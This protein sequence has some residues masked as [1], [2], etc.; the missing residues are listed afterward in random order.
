[1]GI[2]E[3][4]VFAIAAIAVIAIIVI[5][6]RQ[7]LSKGVPVITPPTDGTKLVNSN[8]VLPKSL[9]EDKGLELA[10][11][12][13]VKID[14]FA[15]KYGQPKVVFVKGSPDMSSMCPALLIDPNTNSFL[16]KLDTFAGTEV[17]PVGNIPAKKWIH[18]AISVGQHAMDIYINGKLYLHHT[19]IQLPKQNEGTLHSGVN[20]G[21][22]GQISQLQYFPY[23]LSPDQVST[24]VSQAPASSPKTQT[25]PIPPYFDSSFW[26][27]HK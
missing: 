23:L 20:G 14:D 9:N 12:C 10:V 6:V 24:L 18:V 27:S 21:F 11:A 13:W 17:V 19:L 26:T 2:T 25:D 16:I 8:L 3:I 5:V 4:A 1:M 7:F 15:Y 22:Q